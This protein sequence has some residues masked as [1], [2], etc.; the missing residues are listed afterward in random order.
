[1]CCHARFSYRHNTR[2]AAVRREAA[3]ERF[4]V[5]GHPERQGASYGLTGVMCVRVRR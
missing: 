5:P 4:A 3:P 2:S 1:M